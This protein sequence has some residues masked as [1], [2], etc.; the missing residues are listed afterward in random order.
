MTARAGRVGTTGAS[1]AGCLFGVLLLIVGGYVAVLLA[2]SEIDFRQLRVE[3]QRQAGL[4][5]ELEDQGIRDAIAARVEELQ[6]PAAAAR[7]TI[8]RFPERRI[9]ITIQYPDPIDFFGQWQWART[10]RIQVDQTY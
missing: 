9:Q 7:A 6:L 3:V 10:R 4:A 2:G 5:A 8:R 1:R